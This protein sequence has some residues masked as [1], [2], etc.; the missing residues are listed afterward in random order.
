LEV[1]L[2]NGRNLAEKK[3]DQP[4]LDGAQTARP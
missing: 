4:L 2:G 1:F 3:C